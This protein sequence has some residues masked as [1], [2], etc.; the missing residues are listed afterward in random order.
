[1]KKPRITVTI[2]PPQTPSSTEEDK[3]RLAEFFYLLHS[4]HVEEQR[5]S[6]G[7]DNGIRG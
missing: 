7:S 6:E 4:W 3:K 5:Q 2:I 1:M